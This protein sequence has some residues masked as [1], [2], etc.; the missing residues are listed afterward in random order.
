MV[1]I[2]SV[3]HVKTIKK[4]YAP[5]K[6]SGETGNLQFCPPSRRLTYIIFQPLAGR[7]LLAVMQFQRAPC[8]E[9]HRNP[10]KFWPWRRRWPRLT[11][12]TPFRRA[13]LP[14]FSS[15]I[16]TGQWHGTFGARAAGVV[17]LKQGARADGWG[18]VTALVA[19]GVGAGA[20]RVLGRPPCVLPPSLVFFFWTETLDSI[21]YWLGSVKVLA[22][23]TLTSFSR[24]GRRR[25]T[26]RTRKK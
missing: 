14:F 24:W 19:G 1:P 9:T 21:R 13:L 17:E 20:G 8:P 25:C 2:R 15:F 7:T 16:D 12:P 5:L 18:R 6:I 4:L 11:P 10:T 26:Q 3:I 23:N 22:T